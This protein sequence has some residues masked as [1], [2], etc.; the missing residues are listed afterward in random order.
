MIAAKTMDKLEFLLRML[1]DRGEEHTFRYIRRRVKMIREREKRGYYAKKN[2][3]C[4]SAALTAAHDRVCR[5]DISEL[6]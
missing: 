6:V 2:D 4:G 1:A 5:S 3:H